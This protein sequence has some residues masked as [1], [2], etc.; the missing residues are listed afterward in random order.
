MT[1]YLDFILSDPSEG[2]SSAEYGNSKCWK[3]FSWY[4]RK[5][6]LKSVFPSGLEELSLNQGTRAARKA[7]AII[8]WSRM[9]ASGRY[10]L[11]AASICGLNST[12]ALKRFRPKGSASSTL[13]FIFSSVDLPLRTP[14][15][16][17]AR[18]RFLAADS[19]GSSGLKRLRLDRLH[20]VDL[21]EAVAAVL[22]GELGVQQK[23][24][25]VA[26]G[27]QR[28][29]E[30]DA[31]V[32][33]PGGVQGVHQNGQRFFGGGGGH[34]GDVFK[35][36]GD[37]FLVQLPAQVKQLSV[38][39]REG[40]DQ[41]DVVGWRRPHNSHHQTDGGERRKERAYLRS[42]PESII[43]HA[44]SHYAAVERLAPVVCM[45][46]LGEIVGSTVFQ[47]NLK[48]DIVRRLFT[49]SA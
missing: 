11:M 30:A 6:L 10:R 7:G 49:D 1:P 16:R 40:G 19:F 45:L 41:R 28:L 25:P 5:R 37:D 26:A 18:A 38:V 17:I 13:S 47:V 39:L 14:E 42:T 36:G 23:D 48:V 12:Q 44:E 24:H 29:G 27:G 4:F 43:D 35:S 22:A 34:F 8:K 15:A 32:Q 9:R 33:V 21:L 3:S 2:R 20:Q 46:V 31:G